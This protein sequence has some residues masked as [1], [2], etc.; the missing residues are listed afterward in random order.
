[1]ENGGGKEQHPGTPGTAAQ[2]MSMAGVHLSVRPSLYLFSPLLVTLSLLSVLFGL[3]EGM[4]VA[5]WFWFWFWLSSRL[6]HD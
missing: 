2:P 1:M 4:D 3:D 6:V 5:V